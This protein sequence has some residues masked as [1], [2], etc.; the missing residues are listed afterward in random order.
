MF[1][2]SDFWGSQHGKSVNFGKIA[3]A[4]PSDIY[5]FHYIYLY[6]VE[7]IEDA[8]SAGGESGIR[9]HVTLR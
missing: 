4:A 2:C 8:K 1:G 6:F 5:S 3:I 7:S 9:T